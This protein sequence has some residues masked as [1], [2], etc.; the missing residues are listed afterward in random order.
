MLTQDQCFRVVSMFDTLKYPVELI[1]GDGRA[2]RV[3]DS[4][5][6]IGGLEALKWDGE[7]AHA[8]GYLYMRAQ[9]LPGMRLRVSDRNPAAQDVLTLAGMFMRSFAFK[10]RASDRDAAVY[11]ILFDSPN[12]LEI[13]RLSQEHGLSLHGE[14]C[15]VVFRLTRGVEAL[16]R[17]LMELFPGT[18][19]IVADLG[20]GT[21]V[22]LRDLSGTT[23][24]EVKE[25]VL[26][27]G[28]TVREETASVPVTGIGEPCVGLEH[29][30][31]SFSQARRAIEVGL[32]HHPGNNVFIYRNLFLERLIAD[33]PNPILRD[34]YYAMFTRRN[35]RLFNPE[36]LQ[37]IDYFFDC[38]LNVSETARRLYIHRNTLVYRLDKV[39]KATGLDLRSFDDAAAF[40]VLRMIGREGREHGEL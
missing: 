23:Y 17:A 10:D 24:E 16:E 26:A 38:N 19:D 33:V 5:Q 2:Y 4:S 36:M 37:T 14:L 31:V 18:D 9:G 7:F 13:E 25:L 28:D 15:A 22:L 30:I 29:A 1:D 8:G 20:A 12:A 3:G 32:R 40:K 27:L 39:Q 6:R 35:E 21:L 34:Y 11:R